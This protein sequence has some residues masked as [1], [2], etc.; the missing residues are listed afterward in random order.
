MRQQLADVGVSMAVGTDEL[1]SR[2]EARPIV[3]EFMLDAG[4]LGQFL[5]VDPIA[6]GVEDTVKE[7]GPAVAEEP[8]TSASD[9]DE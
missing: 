9:R 7:P 6:T 5:E 8:L 1:L 2:K 4:L 3:A